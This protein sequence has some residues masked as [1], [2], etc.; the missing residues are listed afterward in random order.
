MGAAGLAD[1]HERLLW[2]PGQKRIFIPPPLSP[3]QWDAILTEALAE[4]YRP[5]MMW[6]PSF[7]SVINARIIS[8]GSA[9]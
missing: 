6:S 2:V 7:V 8:R 9:P 4:A 5:G 1:D 3:P